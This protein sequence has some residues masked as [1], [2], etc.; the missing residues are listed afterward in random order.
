MAVPTSRPAMLRE[1]HQKTLQFPSQ[2]CVPGSVWASRVPPGSPGDCS[3]EL[4]SELSPEQQM[5]SLSG[6]GADGLGKGASQGS[7]AT[8][9]GAVPSS[10]ARLFLLISQETALKPG[11]T[12]VPER[13][14]QSLP[15]CRSPAWTG[16]GLQHSAPTQ[17]LP[18]VTLQAKV[19]AVPILG[20]V[21]I[22]ERT[23]THKKIPMSQPLLCAMICLGFW[24]FSAFNCLL[25]L[26]LW[27]L[28]SS[29]SQVLACPL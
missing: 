11:K 1:G 7:R 8:K 28:R 26:E 27:L 19:A 23:H 16:E 9:Q 14:E 21:Q 24:V 10:R 25:F 13:R 5:C 20:L 22:M 2:D 4:T 29:A 17:I 15:A 18:S 12:G 6:G 3:L